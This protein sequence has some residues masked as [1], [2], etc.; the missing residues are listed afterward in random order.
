MESL[1]YRY[2]NICINKHSAIYEAD[3]KVRVVVSHEDPGLPNWIE[4][5]DHHGGTMCWRWYRIH[6]GSQAI[7]PSCRIV[8][9]K[10]IKTSMKQE[11]VITSTDFMNQPTWFSTLNMIWKRT[12][13]HGAAPHLNKDDL[14]STARRKTGLN[15]LGK[16]FWD[17]PLDGC[18]IPKP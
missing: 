2:H 17:E 3:G 4:T 10:R 16:D 7:Q 18:R 15:D 9:I 12:Y 8:K 13:P 5:A 11:R 14:I 1:D 6:P